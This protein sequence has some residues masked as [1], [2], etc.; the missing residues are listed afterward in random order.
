MN[1]QAKSR[2]TW[3][4]RTQRTDEELNR[5]CK[6]FFDALIVPDDWKFIAWDS[7][8]QTDGATIS[9][10]KVFRDM[11][12]KG[13]EMMDYKIVWIVYSERGAICEKMIIDFGKFKKTCI[14]S[15]KTI[16]GIN[17]YIKLHYFEIDE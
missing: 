13:I 17:E 8:L 6:E 5:L 12:T 3:G 1:P 10:G 9:V 4:V 2:G 16:E 11:R 7:A 14:C 15:N